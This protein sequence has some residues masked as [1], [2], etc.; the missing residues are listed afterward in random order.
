M[1]LH[2]KLDQKKWRSLLPELVFALNCSKSSAIKSVPYEV[3]FGRTPCL[4]IDVTFG[5]HEGDQVT[6]VVSPQDYLEELQF[7]LSDVFDQVAEKLKLSKLKMQKQYNRNLRVFDYKKGQKVWLKVKHYKTGENRKLT[8]RRRGP[9]TVVDKLPNG[10]N[11]KIKTI[12]NEEKVVH[13]DRLYPV[14]GDEVVELERNPGVADEGRSSE[15]DPQHRSVQ[16]PPVQPQTTR[17]PVDVDDESSS[18]DSSGSHSDYDPLSDDDSSDES[19]ADVELPDAV[20]HRY[21]QRVRHRRT[22]PGGVS[23]SD[24]QLD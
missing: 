23:W 24:I 15:P 21:P 6:D 13:H 2:R 17:H 1:L 14:R 16:Q 11:F 4:P 12:A 10:V 22:I 5:T 20:A 19:N 9:W 18:S 8:P 7:S 3:V